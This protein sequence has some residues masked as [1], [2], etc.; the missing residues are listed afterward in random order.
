MDLPTREQIDAISD[1]E[2][3]LAIREEV[4]FA[5]AK[6]EVDLEF[7]PGDEDWAHRARGALAVHNM[8]FGQLSRRIYRLQQATKGP[9]STS[10]TTE[11][12][13]AKAA[14]KEAVALRQMAET[15]A[16]R[17]KVQADRLAFQERTLAVLERTSWL[18]FFHK[19]ANRL[20]DAPTFEK[21]ANAAQRDFKEQF[22]KEVEASS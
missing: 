11:H 4:E 7:R 12:I 3:L 18:A 9:R 5:T 19:H 16:R 21:V 15:E 6:I 10:P 2:S 1:L 17:A 13:N 22:K 20:L 8:C 14:K